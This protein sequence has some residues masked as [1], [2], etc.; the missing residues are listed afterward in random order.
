MKAII[1]ERTERIKQV[2]CNLKKTKDLYGEIQ[3]PKKIILNLQFFSK[4]VVWDSL[5]SF[6]KNEFFD[7]N[8]PTEKFFKKYKSKIFN[9]P[10]ITPNGL[11]LPKVEILCSFNLFNKAVFDL[12]D[13]LNI[14]NSAD[15]ACPVN[16]RL[17]FGI[18]R[19][20]AFNE[21][22]K[23]STY[24]HTDIWAGQ[25][26]NELMIHTPIFGDFDKN[27]ISICDPKDSFYPN[28][29]KTIDHF[30]NDGSIVTNHMDENGHTPKLKVGT[31][32]VFDS[33]L[34]HKTKSS[35]SEIRG[36]V[37]FPIKLK[38]KINSDI[39]QNP[40][41]DSEYKSTLEWSKIGKQKMLVSK[42]GILDKNWKDESKN[43]YADRFDII[44]IL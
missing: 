7:L 10:N 23:S 33:F 20:K 6:Y 35:G 5:N 14:Q 3:L 21:R 28:F 8:I 2:F 29:V 22:P 18:N 34:F 26:S 1:K 36:I 40:L 39:Y 31:S 15:V 27:G 38:N 42:N 30:F 37:S 24:W 12:V 44:D 13:F 25:N 32:Y 9:L 11:V 4:L 17:N 41:R 43:V 19:D 16:L